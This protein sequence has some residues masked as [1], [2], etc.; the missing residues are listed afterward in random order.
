MLA[1]RIINRVIKVSQDMYIDPIYNKIKSMAAR[2]TEW[3]EYI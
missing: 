3:R 2:R 1:V